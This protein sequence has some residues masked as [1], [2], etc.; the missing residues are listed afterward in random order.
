[1]FLTGALALAGGIYLMNEW[2][3]LNGLARASA[4]VL[5]VLGTLLVLP[6]LLIWI[7]GLVLRYLLRD[8]KKDF[9]GLS[10]TLSSVGE[11]LVGNNKAMYD[12]IHE[13]RAANDED[14]ATLDRDAYERVTA[15]LSSLGFRHL[16]DVVDQTIEEISDVT[17]VIRVLGSTD[18]TTVASLFHFT[19]PGGDRK[20]SLMIDLQ[21]E[22]TDGMFL[23]TSNLKG[24]DQTTA[25]TGIDRRQHPLETPMADL[26][27]SHESEKQKSLAA[28]AGA[29]TCVVIHTLADALDSEKR[30]Q[31]V[32]NAFRKQIGY[33]DPEEVRRIARSVQD[34]GD[35]NSG[36]TLSD[37]AAQAADEARRKEQKRGESQQ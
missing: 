28:K 36:E 1:M 3:D 21:S 18:G 8:I 12:K 4:V 9:E 10:S 32:K 16:G 19:M 26:V 31:A 22:F 29:A 35:E 15:E 30:R 37:L 7:V 24:L 2:N 11:A 17:T 23:V 25:A 6:K 5:V 33:V 27:R 34:E 14:F 13:Y 20:G